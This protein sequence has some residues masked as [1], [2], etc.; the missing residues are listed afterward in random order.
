MMAMPFRSPPL[1]MLG[2][3]GGLPPWVRAIEQHVDPLPHFLPKSIHFVGGTHT[4]KWATKYVDHYK[5]R[6]QLLIAMLM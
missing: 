5:V 1:F 2:G 3:A 4:M 6:R